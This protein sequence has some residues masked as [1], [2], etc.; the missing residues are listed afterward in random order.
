MLAARGETGEAA[1]ASLT[2]SGV[3]ML[4]RMVLVG[5]DSVRDLKVENSLEGE[6]SVW[7]GL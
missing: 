4:G 2:F 7:V 6:C 1:V 5:S 3:P